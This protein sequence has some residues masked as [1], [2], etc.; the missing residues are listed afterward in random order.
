MC[1]W[2][3]CVDGFGNDFKH[4]SLELKSNSGLQL[5]QIFEVLATSGIFLLWL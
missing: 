2:V 5:N 3:S 1:C 4:F